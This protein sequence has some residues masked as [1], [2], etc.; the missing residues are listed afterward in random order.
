MLERINLTSIF[1][2]V[3]LI[4]VGPV[5]AL[6]QD[7]VI[8]NITVVDVETGTLSENRTVIING[9]IIESIIPSG[10]NNTYP[11]GTTVI[12]GTGQYLTPGFVNTHIHIAIGTAGFNMSDG[13]PKLE[14]DILA[15]V[16]EYTLPLLLANGITTARDPGGKTEVT[17]SVKKQLENARL[18][19]PELFVAGA[20]IDTTYFKNL[21]AQIKTKEDIAKA[22]AKQQREGVDYIKLYTSLNPELLEYGIEEAHKMGLGTIAH[23]QNTSWTEAARRGLDNIVHIIP[24]NEQLLPEQYR[25]EFTQS[26]AMGSQWMYK[27]FEYADLNSPEIN[28]MVSTLKKYNVSVDPTLILFHSVFFA[29]KGTYQQNPELK[30]V[31]DSMV[32]N[33]KTFNYNVGWSE[34]DYRRANAVWNK[35]EKFTKLLHTNGVMLTAGTDNN[36]P[37]IPAGESF[38]RELELLAETGISDSDV[39]KIATING[40]KM[41]GIDHRVGTVHEGKEADLVILKRNPLDDISNSRQVE[42]VIINGHV[43]NPGD[44]K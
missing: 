33:W 31:P 6:G 40:A 29:N 43:Y 25:N 36:N 35:V 41:L 18:T 38:H 32:E 9:E 13:A 30:Y 21:V 26:V 44:L 39:L 34:E 7:L 28:E 22:I 2:A 4:S 11:N 17:T 19:G 37:W 14:M 10:N 3:I 15:E 27:W 5:T 1:I 8:R 24:G 12:D 16:P 42:V 20:I 23:L